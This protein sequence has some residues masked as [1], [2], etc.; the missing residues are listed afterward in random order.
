M[1]PAALTLTSALKFCWAVSAIFNEFK[2][3]AVVE[4]GMAVRG[5][6][7]FDSTPATAIFPLFEVANI[8]KVN[9]GVGGVG[10]VGR[11][12]DDARSGLTGVEGVVYYFKTAISGKAGIDFFPRKIQ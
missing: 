9:G 10:D 6:V 11:F 12:G 7:L 4:K 2:P 1:L 3:P 8:S 5:V